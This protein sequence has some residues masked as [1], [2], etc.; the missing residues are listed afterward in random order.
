MKYL[1]ISLQIVLGL[2]IVIF[3]VKESAYTMKA[4][5]LI[6]GTQH[7]GFFIIYLVLIPIYWIIGLFL[8]NLGMRN[9]SKI[10]KQNA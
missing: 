2:A 9:L 6:W 1:K 7:T 3:S 5:S 4:F 8:I 10:K